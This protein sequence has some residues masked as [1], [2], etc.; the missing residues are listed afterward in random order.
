M[1]HAVS[2]GA[3]FYEVTGGG[4]RDG[5]N[6]PK[7]SSLFLKGL[8]KLTKSFKVFQNKKLVINLLFMSISIC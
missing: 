6:T 1:L 2:I 8:S 4:E 5:G 7:C 3:Y